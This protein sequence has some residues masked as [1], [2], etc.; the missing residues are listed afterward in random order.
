MHPISTGSAVCKRSF[1]LLADGERAPLG[2][3]GSVLSGKPSAQSLRS[4][5]LCGECVEVKF[6]ARDAEVAEKA[7][8]KLKLGHFRF[9]LEDSVRRCAM[10][11]FIDV[12]QVNRSNPVP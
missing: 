6:T 9:A 7:Q 3:A 11:K 1:F 2:L 10:L 5:R 4:L 8:R 12:S